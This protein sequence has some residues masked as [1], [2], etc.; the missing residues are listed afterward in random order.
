MPSILAEAKYQLDWLQTMQLPEGSV[1]ASGVSDAISWR[2]HRPGIGHGTTL[3]LA[4]EHRGDR[5]FHGGFSHGFTCLST[6]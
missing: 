1:L 2:C 4:T 3:F 6:V 5:L